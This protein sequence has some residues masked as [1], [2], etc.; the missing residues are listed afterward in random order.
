MEAAVVARP[1]P[2]WGETP[3]AFITLKPN[4]VRPTPEA[5]I[6]F[7]KE[8]LAGYKTPKHFEFGDLPKTL[9]GKIQ[10]N[11]LRERVAELLNE[12]S[13]VH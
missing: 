9:T 4:T 2:K 8:R 5:L 7:C 3:M 10:K 11:I 1:D 6:V 12:E 13:T